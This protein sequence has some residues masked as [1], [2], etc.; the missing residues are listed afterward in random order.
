[1]KELKETLFIIIGIFNFILISSEA[2]TV[3]ILIYKSIFCMLVFFIL[4]L[5]N[6]KYKIITNKL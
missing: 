5:I 2:E 3:K 1:M 6:R 4:Y